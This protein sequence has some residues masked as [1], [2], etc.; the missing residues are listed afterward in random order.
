MENL[1]I[2]IWT[3]AGFML[4]AIPFS[5][6]LSR[7]YGAQD[8]RS[9]D[10]QNPGAFNA[11]RAG[12]WKAGLP[13]LLLDFFK[14]AIPVGLATH[15]AGIVGL[16]L[17]PIALA[18]IAGHA[19]SPFLR[20][21]GGKAIA[22]SFGVWAGLTLGEAALILGLFCGLF[23]FTVVQKGWAAILGMSGL[24]LYLVSR[25]APYVLIAIWA[26]NVAILWW[27]HRDE[28]REPPHLSPALAER[29]QRML[30]R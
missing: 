29:V 8:P 28:F 25:G 11:W 17:I 22:V 23:Y 30:G 21:K 1:Q 12:G 27:K 26:G 5:V 24:L 7:A 6:L 10:D 14:G 15:R 19:F 2:L 9:L 3:L 13:T 4:G 18:P 16:G 20:F